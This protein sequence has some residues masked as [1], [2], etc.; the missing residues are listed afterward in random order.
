MDGYH[1]WRQ[2][3]HPPF[4][5][6]EKV[7]IKVDDG[8]GKDGHVTRGPAEAFLADWRPSGEGIPYQSLPGRA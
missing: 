7:F 3:D 6:T 5:L 4:R 8:T 1:T 2:A